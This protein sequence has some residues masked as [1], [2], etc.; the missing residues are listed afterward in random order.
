M[1]RK[2]DNRRMH[3]VPMMSMTIIIIYC[4]AAHAQFLQHFIMEIENA[5]EGK[6]GIIQ[7]IRWILYSSDW[8][9]KTAYRTRYDLE[10]E[11]EYIPITRCNIR[12][13]IRLHCIDRK[14]SREKRILSISMEINFNLKSTTFSTIHHH[15]TQHNTPHI[16]RAP[17]TLTMFRNAHSGWRHYRYWSL[18][19]RVRMFLYRFARW[20]CNALLIRSFVLSCRLDNRVNVHT[21]YKILTTHII[22]QV[23]RITTAYERTDGENNKSLYRQQQWQICFIYYSDD[24]SVRTILT[25]IACLRSCVYGTCR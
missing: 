17:I 10:L 5:D 19:E 24:R 3:L 25:F 13:L 22:T 9:P 11:S 18:S 8:M 2:V 23:V 15:T 16:I 6:T 1:Y 21:K 7:R 14:D 12:I 20:N 4:C